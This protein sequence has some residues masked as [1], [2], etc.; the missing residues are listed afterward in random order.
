[1]LPAKTCSVVALPLR[2]RMAGQHYA[3]TLTHKIE[4]K[5]H[6]E[7]DPSEVLNEIIYCTRKVCRLRDSLWLMS[8]PIHHAAVSN[9]VSLHHESV[10]VLT[11][12][13][14]CCTMH[15]A[16][17]ASGRRLLDA[18]GLLL[19]PELLAEHTGS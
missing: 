19:F 13:R 1:M 5:L 8:W 12:C 17:L 10:L 4:M 16:H 15:R 14:A 9:M 11:Q 7:T 3:H 18:C 6:V 2:M